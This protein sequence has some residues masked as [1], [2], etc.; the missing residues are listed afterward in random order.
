MTPTNNRNLPGPTFGQ[1][2]LLVLPFRGD[3]NLHLLQLALEALL[4]VPAL[5]CTLPYQ[6]DSFY[7][8]LPLVKTDSTKYI[9]VTDTEV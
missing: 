8:H 4:G 1:D 6:D 7:F 5:S 2:T 9:D 3:P